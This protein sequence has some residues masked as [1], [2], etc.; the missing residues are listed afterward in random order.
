MLEVFL[1][2]PESGINMKAEL[3]QITDRVCEN[4]NTDCKFVLKQRLYWLE[5]SRSLVKIQT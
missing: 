4:M 5:A 1:N 3:E 2:G